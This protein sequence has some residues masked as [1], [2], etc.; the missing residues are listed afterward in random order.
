MAQAAVPADVV[1]RHLSIKHTVQIWPV[2]SHQ[3]FLA[4]ATEDPPA[5]FRL[6]AYVR[7]GRRP[8]RIEPRAVKQRPKPFPRLQTTRRKARQNLRLYGHPRKLPAWTSTIQVS[9]LYCT[10]A[11]SDV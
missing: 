4:D 3:Q 9:I 5:V 11:K 6:V 8:G 10:K 2:C 7:V 1:P